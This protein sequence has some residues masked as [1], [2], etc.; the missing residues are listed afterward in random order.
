M[1]L[2]SAVTQLQSSGI[3]GQ[4]QMKVASMMLKTQEQSGAAAVQL[5]DAA[6]TGVSQAGDAVVAQATGLGGLVDAYA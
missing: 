3:I 6:T 1:D 4:I 5:I 2:V